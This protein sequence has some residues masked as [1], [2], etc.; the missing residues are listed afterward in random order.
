VK[1]VVVHVE[2]DD[3][4]GAE[5]ARE[6][7]GGEPDG[8]EA[9]DEHDVVAADADLLQALVDGAEAAGDLRAVGVREGVGQQDQ[10]FLFG[11]EVVGHA[12]VALPAVG[13]A[14]PLARA[15]YHV[16]APTVVAEAAAGDVVDDHPVALLEAP[17]P[18]PGLDDLA[19][20]LVA[21]DD[22]V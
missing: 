11:E 14:P 19:A 18:R 8:A 21:G 12:A 22:A 13:P 2:A 10:V 16:A 3:A 4:R 17:A 5:G 1:P 6:H 20:R 15:A 9:G 7:G